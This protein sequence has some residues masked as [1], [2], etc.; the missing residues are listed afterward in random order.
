MFEV[1]PGRFSDDQL[2]LIKEESDARHPAARLVEVAQ[3]KV[4]DGQFW[5]ACRFRFAPPGRRIYEMHTSDAMLSLVSGITGHTLTASRASYIYYGIGDFLGTHIDHDVCRYTAIIPLSDPIEPLHLYPD[6][7][8][9]TA[10]DLFRRLESGAS[11]GPPVVVDLPWR[12]MV[13]LRGSAIP[14][15]RPV[16]RT[17]CRIATLCFDAR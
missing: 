8:G 5:G 17:E 9:V 11:M 12:G 10:T 3:C 13:L 14:H 2:S 15:A 7:A 6:A 4:E 1:I 16:T